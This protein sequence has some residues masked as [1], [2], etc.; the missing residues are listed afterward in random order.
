MTALLLGLVTGGRAPASSDPRGCDFLAWRDLSQFSLEIGDRPGTRLAVSPEIVARVAADELITSWNA[1][2]PPGSTLE[3]AVRAIYPEQATKFYILGRWSSDPDTAPR[4]SVPDQADDAGDVRT[5]TLAL[6]RPTRRFQWRLTLG[7]GHEGRFPHL[8][9]LAASL[10]QTTWTGPALP[11]NRAAWGR[12]LDVPKRSQL[13]YSGGE[14]WCSPASTA[15]VLGWWSARLN[16]PEW[17]WDVPAIAR[18]VHDPRWP[19]AG[20]WA[21]NTAFAGSLPGLLAYVTRLSDVAELEDWIAAGLPVV[22]S[23]NNTV[24]QGRVG[25]PSG[26]LVVCVGFTENGDVVLNDPGTRH[27]VRR[28]F[29]RQQLVAA[30][31]HSRRTVYVIQPEPTPPPGDRFGHWLAVGEPATEDSARPSHRAR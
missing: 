28:A 11:P 25:P 15:M 16:R 2:M 31:A 8:K 13:A 22:L 18:W 26:H 1:D 17:Q 5:D 27:E 29:P 10:A 21:F 6:R 20:N 9:L 7:A 24:L 12:I 14:Q 4:E 23:V 30:W 3:I 19:G